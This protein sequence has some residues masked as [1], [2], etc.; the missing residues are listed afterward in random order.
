MQEH[1]TARMA[2]E[3]QSSASIACSVIT[4]Q[5]GHLADVGSQRF[6]RIW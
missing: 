1:K 3:Q 2:Q 4:I 5:G 6:T